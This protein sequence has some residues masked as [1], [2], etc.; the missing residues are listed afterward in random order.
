[1]NKKKIEK[2]ALYIREVPCN[3][4]T[5]CCQGDAIRLQDED[6]VADYMT[7]PHPYLKNIFMLAHKENGDCIYL[8][9]SGC[10]IHDRAPSLCRTAD[11]RSVAIKLDFAKAKQL[12]L[13]GLLD[14]KVWDKGNDLLKEMKSEILKN[15]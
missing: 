5:I 4:C 6:I 15:N 13:A 7:V 10:S 12:H 8:S 3:G 1:M 2:Q 9:D 14:L 11:C